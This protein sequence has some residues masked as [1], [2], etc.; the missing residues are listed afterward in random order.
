MELVNQL[1]RILPDSV[2]P[3]VLRYPPGFLPSKVTL[4]ILLLLL[5]SLFFII[6]I[7]II[8]T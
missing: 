4:I 7:I 8:I 2:L 1:V 6:I 3:Y 5:L